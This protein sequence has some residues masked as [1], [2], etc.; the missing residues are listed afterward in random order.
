[1]SIGTMSAR[2]WQMKAELAEEASN[3]HTR[4]G[5]QSGGWIRSLPLYALVIGVFGL[6]LPWQKGRDFL[7]S[8]ILGAYACLGVVFAAPVAAAEFERF[9]SVQKALARVIISVFYGQLLAAVMLVLGIATVYVLRGVR[10]VVG[11]D[12]QSLAECATLGLMLSWA[13]STVAVWLSLKISPR[14]A[15]TV[16]RLVFLGLLA[17]FYL[18]SGWLPAVAVRGAGIALLVSILLCGALWS[19]VASGRP[20]A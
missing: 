4:L 16:V 20:K 6:L 7:D 11:P 8:V 10:I 2:V 1:L 3:L 5:F 13:V 12:F 18:R 19:T 15:K 14:A 9:P 17:A